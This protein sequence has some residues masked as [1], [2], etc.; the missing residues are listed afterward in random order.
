MSIDPICRNCSRCGAPNVIALE[1]PAYGEHV[2][3]ARC[4][5]PLD[6]RRDLDSRPTYRPDQVKTY[7]GWEG[8]ALQVIRCP[9]CRRLNHGVVVPGRGSELAWYANAKP[10]NPKAFVLEVTCT[11]CKAMFVIE[12]DAFPIES[13]R[14]NYC[15]TIMI[16]AHSAAAIPEDHRAAFERDYGRGPDSPAKI[17]DGEGHSLWVVCP[18]CMNH[19]LEQRAKRKCDEEKGIPRPRSVLQALEHQDPALALTRIRNG[20]DLWEK[21]LNGNMSL[22]YAA[23]HGYLDVLKE[24]VEKGFPLDARNDAGVT[25]LVYAM[26]NGQT[27]AAKALWRRRKGSLVQPLG[28]YAQLA[29]ELC[30][31]GVEERTLPKEE[32][33][34]GYFQKDAAGK[35]ICNARAIEIGQELNTLGGF[36]MMQHAAEEVGETLGRKAMSD[37]SCIWTGVGCWMH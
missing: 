20:G 10:E 4:Q 37:L 32:A 1:T 14:C 5:K 28:G 23:A 31:I 17:K 19:T 6:D 29:F 16:G 30:G 15:G 13:P 33:A 22:H 12:W 24:I 36:S 34:S 21:D 27:E 2:I 11:Y 8:I 25:P 7:F 18:V 9:H 26:H 35:S 3:C